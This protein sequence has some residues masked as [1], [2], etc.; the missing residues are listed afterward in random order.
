MVD[1]AANKR[2][3][4]ISNRV[5]RNIHELKGV[6]TFCLFIH[7]LLNK[8][9][10][11]VCTTTLKILLKWVNR[12][13]QYKDNLIQQLHILKKKGLINYNNE[14][15]GLNDILEIEAM[16]AESPV[17]T[18]L[19]INNEI[20]Y[21]E[22]SEVHSD[23][24]FSVWLHL[25]SSQDKYLHYASISAQTIA[26][27]LGLSSKTVYKAL[28]SLENLGIITVSRGIFYVSTQ[29]KAVNRYKVHNFNDHIYKIK[30]GIAKP[31]NRVG[32]NDNEKQMDIRIRNVLSE[33]LKY[34]PCIF[35]GD[36]GRTLLHI[37]FTLGLKK[38]FR[39]SSSRDVEDMIEIYGGVTS[40]SFKYFAIEVIKPLSTAVQERL[41]YF[42]S[43]SR[44][45]III[46][47]EDKSFIESLQKSVKYVYST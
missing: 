6:H 2:Y 5:I 34:T 24:L 4:I 32:I 33:P 39:V 40:L 21:I 28:Y 37:F 11:S 10:K 31:I 12:D 26:D 17:T 38:V 46:I 47:C 36:Y 27:N 19:C 14:T 45:P 23:I 43:N 8:N 18:C 20:F 7:I 29:R 41:L 44:I 35:T 13:A 30:N 3:I 42:T 25:K 15:P 1:T 16:R 22:N 9:W